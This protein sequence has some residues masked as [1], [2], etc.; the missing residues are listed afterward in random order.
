MIR[1]GRLGVLVALAIMCGVSPSQAQEVRDDALKRAVE[2]RFDVLPLRDGLALRPKVPVA[3]VRS[4][5]IT[6]GTIAIDGQPAT[7]SE[8]RA[9]LGADADSILQLSYLSDAARVALFAATPVTPVAPAPPAAPSAPAVEAPPAPVE[10]PPPPRP[11]RPRPDRRNGDRVRIGGDV[12]VEEGEL[13]DGDVV[14][15]G[16]AVRVDGEVEGDV[17]SVGGSVTLGPRSIVQ[18]DVT[19]VGGQLR[20]DAGSEV[21]GKAQEVSLGGFEFGDWSWRRNPVGLWWQSMLGSAFAFVGTLARVAVLCL[22]A[23][24]VVL[25]GREYMER[26]G[27]VAATSSLKAGAVGFL[28]QILFLPILVITIVV[29]VITIVGIP[30]LLLLPFAV[31]AIAV[32]AL[33]GFTGV[34]YRVGAYATARFGWQEQ[35]PYAVTVIGVLLVMLPVMLSRL[36]SLGGG[37]LFPLALAL[38][39]AGV[40]VEYVAWTVGLGAVALT[41]FRRIDDSRT[42]EPSPAV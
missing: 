7:G 13:I 11:R 29:L 41:R 27:T 37:V 42:G 17:V 31:L 35:S 10:P 40:A 28:A 4:V 21:R 5:E 18:G 22:L 24:L 39:I 6:G 34:A 1:I 15:V 2:R 20:R 8:L 16:G 23:A 14:A 33:V 32:V 9:R 19:V 26:A 38:G 3:G 25:F 12:N 36:A 30:L